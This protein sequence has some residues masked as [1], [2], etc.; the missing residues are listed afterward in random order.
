MLRSV[1]L[2]DESCFRVLHEAFLWPFSLANAVS[3]SAAS[4]MCKSFCFFLRVGRQE[5]KGNTVHGLFCV[6][7]AV[8]AAEQGG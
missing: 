3:A 4:S 6:V 5:T 2:S 1:L 7:R 8:Q